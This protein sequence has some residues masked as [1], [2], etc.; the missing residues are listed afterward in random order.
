M[1]FKIIR[2]FIKGKEEKGVVGVESVRQTGINAMF[3]TEEQQEDCIYKNG[4]IKIRL[5]DDDGNIYYHAYVDDILFS[6]ELVLDWGIGYAGC[7]SVDMHIDSYKKFIGEPKY[8]ESI[9]D[10]G[11]WYSYM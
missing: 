7:S 2:D 1:G 3:M 6:C 11:R 4:K 5:L 8:K 9:S 10:C